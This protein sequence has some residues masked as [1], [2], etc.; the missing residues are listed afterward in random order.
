MKGGIWRSSLTG[1]QG[2]NGDPLIERTNTESEA[3]ILW[4]PDAKS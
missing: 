1:I 2:W 3:P 4:P